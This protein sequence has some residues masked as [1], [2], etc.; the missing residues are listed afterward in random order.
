[1]IV[2]SPFPSGKHQQAR[3]G[4][5]SILTSDIHACSLLIRG[6]RNTS[7]EK[8]NLCTFD[9]YHL[10]VAKI[11]QST[12]SFESWLALGAQ[13]RLKSAVGIC[14]APSNCSPRE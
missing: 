8:C 9:E 10:T 7:S 5:Q 1:M 6:S 12:H 4:Q 3:P 11:T 14:M 2:P 13:S